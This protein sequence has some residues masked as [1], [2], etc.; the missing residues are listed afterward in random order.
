[1][2]S[3]EIEFPNVRLIADERPLP[4]YM[5]LINFA[6][7]SHARCKLYILAFIA[8][9]KGKAAIRRR[10]SVSMSHRRYLWNR[11]RVFIV[12][13]GFFWEVTSMRWRRIDK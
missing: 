10:R 6:H 13:S 9:N 4:K 7:C 5:V 8:I 3:S 1:M 11:I 12:V 2:K